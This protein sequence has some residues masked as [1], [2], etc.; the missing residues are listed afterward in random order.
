MTRVLARVVSSCLG[1]GFL[2]PAPGTWGSAFALV[3]FVLLLAHRP[4]AVQLA[5]VVIAIGVGVWAG[6]VTAAARVHSDPSEVVVDELAGMWLALLA[7]GGLGAWVLAFF[8]FRGFD[9]WKPWPARGFEALPG[10]WGIMADDL[11]AGLYALLVVLAARTA[12]LLA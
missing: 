7:G 11:V 4:L 12:G 10:G 1:T 5:A 9:I 3:V 6:G 8:L 2:R